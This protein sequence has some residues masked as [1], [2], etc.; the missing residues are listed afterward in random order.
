MTVKNKTI[1]IKINQKSGMFYSLFNAFKS[2]KQTDV[3]NL[4]QFL[5]NERAKLIH[6]IKTDKPES[7]YELAKKLDRD[8]KAVRQDIK[9]LQRFGI[10]DLIVSHKNG[11]ERLKPI[12]TLNQL[13][14]TIDL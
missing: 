9:L 5:S 2:D 13:I 7:I 8:F 6:T 11:R 12:V 4:R 1:S 3:T 14:I 10:V